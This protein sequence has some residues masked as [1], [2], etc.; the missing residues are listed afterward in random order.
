MENLTL[1]D[2]SIQTDKVKAAWDKTRPVR[3]QIFPKIPYGIVI[4]CLQYVLD[5]LED[6]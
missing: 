1:S 5:I 3:D 6:V 4:F 2:E